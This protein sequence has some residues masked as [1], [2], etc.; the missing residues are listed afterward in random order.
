MRSPVLAVHTGKSVQPLKWNLD[1]D[2]CLFTSLAEWFLVGWWWIINNAVWRKGSILPPFDSQNSCTLLSELSLGLG[3]LYPGGKMRTHFVLRE[4][5]KQQLWFQTPP[6]S[7]WALGFLAV[8]PLFPALRPLLKFVSWFC[9]LLFLLL[10]DLSSA[11][12][13][14][15][16]TD[17]HLKWVQLKSLFKRSSTQVT[18]MTLALLTK[19]V[20]G[21]WARKL[22]WFRHVLQDK[23]PG[24]LL[25]MLTT[26]KR[27][28]LMFK[29]SGEDR[30]T[31][32]NSKCCDDRPSSP[33]NLWHR[34]YQCVDGLAAGVVDTSCYV[35]ITAVQFSLLRRLWGLFP[36]ALTG[37]ALFSSPPPPLAVKWDFEIFLW[38]G[39]TCGDRLSCCQQRLM[40]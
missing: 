21:V 35:D 26:D 40:S 13:N 31:L 7:V 8:S 6:Y 2:T 33:S 14:L 9:A 38:K 19:E 23:L 24:H 28:V 34:G 32:Q 16:A 18:I 5:R 4:Q 29:G 12:S 36:L 39:L 1:G 10:C 3:G 37:I 25:Y 11:G 30:Y 15:E 17:S 22:G 27:F 20:C